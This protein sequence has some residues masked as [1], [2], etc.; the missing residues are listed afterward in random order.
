MMGMG[1][2]HRERGAG[3]WLDVAFLLGLLL[4]AVDGLGE[5][6]VGIPLLFLSPA[7]LEGLVRRAT[8][9]ELREDPSDLLANAVVHATSG[10]PASATGFAAVYLLLHGLVK[11]G[12]VAAVFVGT[13]KV[14][15]FAVVALAAFLV[16]QVWT[17]AHAPGVG[18]ALLTV[19]D[20]LVLALT[21]R[22][23]RHHRS[24]RQV[25]RSVTAR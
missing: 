5:V 10:L 12:I 22:E 23:W 8:A 6:V 3:W 16:W 7:Q 18:M 14:Y 15:P 13:R 11:L 21:W 17:L 4:K 9:E 19:I 24:L 2:D 20:V 25:W 1:G